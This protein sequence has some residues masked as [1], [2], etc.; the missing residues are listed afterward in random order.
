MRKY[1]DND[2]RMTS[3]DAIERFTN[4]GDSF[5]FANCL[6][7]MPLALTHELIRQE[8]KN[9]MVFQQGGIEEVDQLLEARAIN[10]AVIAYNFR[11][12][13]KRLVSPIDRAMKEGRVE[14]EEMTNHTLL[15][16]MKA[17]AMGYPFIPVLSGIRRTDVVQRQGFLGDQRFGEVKDPFSGNSTLVVK[18]YNPDFALMH[19]QRADKAGNAQLW[20]AMINSKWAALAAKK[21]IISTEEI[22]DTDVIK[23]APHLTIVPAHKVC[24]VVECPWGAHPSELAGHYDNDMVFRAL[25]FAATSEEDSLKAWLDQWVFGVKDRSEYIQQYVDIFG[26]DSLDALKAKP[27]PSVSADYGFSFS[28]T[29]D[30]NGYSETMGM[31]MEEFV[32]M[33][34]VKG[35]MI[36]G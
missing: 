4:D 15:S 10:K 17:G 24:A 2:K 13:G 1:M 3:K 30:D 27:F 21:V 34:E 11:L 6:Y 16:M 18:G 26:K 25:F 31:N 23:S 20:G 9:L 28:R 19:V 32:N 22:V 14:V 35:G 5:V 33:L 36:H 29:W 7:S 12:G 8:R